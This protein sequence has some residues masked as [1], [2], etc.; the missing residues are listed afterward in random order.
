MHVRV[1]FYSPIVSLNAI[2]PRIVEQSAH[3]SSPLIVVFCLFGS[4]WKVQVAWKWDTSLVCTPETTMLLQVENLLFPTF[5]FKSSIHSGSNPR[6]SSVNVFGEPTIHPAPSFIVAMQGRSACGIC[7]CIEHILDNNWYSSPPVLVSHKEES[8]A[9]EWHMH[10][11]IYLCHG[12]REAKVVQRFG[13]TR[14]DCVSSDCPVMISWDRKRLF[15]SWWASHFENHTKTWSFYT[16]KENGSICSFIL[17]SSI[18]FADSWPNRLNFLHSDAIPE[19]ASF[20]EI[21]ERIK[22]EKLG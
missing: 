5:V 10:S 21:P 7:L 19:T 20:P 9:Y 22:C 16:F 14:L 3:D 12:W 15:C 4:I 18:N 6:E 13:V 11:S 1:S 8:P 17:I 2:H